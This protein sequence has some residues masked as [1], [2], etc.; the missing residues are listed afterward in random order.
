MKKNLSLLC[1]LFA[2]LADF[3]FHLSLFLVLFRVIHAFSSRLKKFNFF[4]RKKKTG[5]FERLLLSFVVTL[6]SV[7]SL[8]IL[9]SKRI[10]ISSKLS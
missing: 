2:L 5:F 8:C 3:L 10:Y 9:S 7:C 4:A 1:A 6:S